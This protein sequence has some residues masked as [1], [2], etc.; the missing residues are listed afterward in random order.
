MEIKQV[1][2]ISA[3]C[4]AYQTAESADLVI[5]DSRLNETSR[6]FATFPNHGDDK[7]K[8]RD[9][10]VDMSV[11]KVHN[12]SDNQL[13]LYLPGKRGVGLYNP[14]D[15]KKKVFSDF[16]MLPAAEDA[17][18]GLLAL[19]VEYSKA[20]KRIVG[21]VRTVQDQHIWIVLNTKTKEKAATYCHEI[22]SSGKS[23]GGFTLSLSGQYIISPVSRDH[24]IS[25]VKSEQVCTL[26]ILKVDGMCYLRSYSLP[27]PCNPPYVVTRFRRSNIFGVGGD[28]HLWVGI[29]NEEQETIG[30]LCILPYLHSGPIASI[31]IIGDNIY[32]TSKKDNYINEI[33]IYF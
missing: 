19:S 10:L 32:T 13:I 21:I 16:W 12:S 6:V 22:Y 28:Q 4:S 5:T 11:I 33:R 25:R 14:S 23:W 7:R 3:D 24:T 8:L 15:K 9:N 31:E 20:S 18:L 17:A 26:L 1:V 29:L 2:S 30:S 27:L